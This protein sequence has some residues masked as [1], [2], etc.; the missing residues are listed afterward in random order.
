MIHST[1]SLNYKKKHEASDRKML[2]Q[3]PPGDGAGRVEPA[4]PDG[5]DGRRDAGGLRRRRPAA[6]VARPRRLRPRQEARKLRVHL[7][8]VG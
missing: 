8:L 5:V 2:P 1:A 7:W 4:V 3:V 6:E